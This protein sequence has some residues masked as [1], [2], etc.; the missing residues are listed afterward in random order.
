M[1]KIRA[2]TNVLCGACL[3]LLL[4]PRGAQ[5]AGRLDI[6]APDRLPL[7]A[8]RVLALDGGSR[9]LDGALEVTVTGYLDE[10]GEVP[11]LTV[12]GQALE[13]DGETR[14][15]LEFEKGEASLPVVAGETGSFSLTLE[16]KG[17]A[18]T[19]DLEAVSA[20]A[21]ARELAPDRLTVTVSRE[22]SALAARTAVAEK[23]EGVL[24]PSG[25][26]DAGG[27]VRVTGDAQEGFSITLTGEGETVPLPPGRLRA[28]GAGGTAAG[29]ADRGLYL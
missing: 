23:M 1:S 27:K 16:A 26:T 29:G 28:G 13:A 17:R 21:W 25:F 12:G 18:G 3:A 5:A 11:A 19:V 7:G 6:E 8:E 22:A 10:A 2:L 20:L 4:M 24:A 14:L 9:S 15:T